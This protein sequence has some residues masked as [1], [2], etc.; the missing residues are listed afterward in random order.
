MPFSQG[1]KDSF[2]KFFESISQYEGM[3]VKE[4]REKIG[5]FYNNT[6]Y[7]DYYLMSNLPEY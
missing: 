4:V 1:V 7:Y 3:D 5:T 6:F 2:E